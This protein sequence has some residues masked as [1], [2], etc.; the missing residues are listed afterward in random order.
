[1]T[2]TTS[3]RWTSATTQSHDAGRELAGGGGN[4]VGRRASRRDEFELLG[5]LFVI[6]IVLVVLVVTVGISPPN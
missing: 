3:G 4:R 2:D 1:V 5:F 6:C